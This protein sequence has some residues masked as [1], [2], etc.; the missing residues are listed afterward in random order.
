RS[1]RQLGRGRRDHQLRRHH[2]DRRRQRLMAVQIQQRRDTAANWASVNPVLA[3]G[4]VGWEL[5][6]G[7]AKLGNGVDDWTALPYAVEPGG[8]GILDAPSDG[9][10]YGRKDGAWAAVAGGSGSGDVVGP[11]SAVNNRI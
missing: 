6:T 8:G 5:D 10:T 3:E 7:K 1:S 4:E 9:T 11:A 2:S